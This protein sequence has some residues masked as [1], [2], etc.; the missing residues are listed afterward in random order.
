MTRK[1]KMPFHSCED[2]RIYYEIHGDGSPLLLISGLG[3]GTSSWYGQTP[4]FEQH[5]RTITFDNRG[6]GLSDTPPGPYRMSRFAEDALCLLDRLQIK[7]TFA[8]GLSMGGMIALEL[9]LTAPERIGALVLGC[10]H[11]GG[12]V[13]IA[14]SPEVLE[15]LLANEGLS[16]EQIID[17][18]LPLFFSE[19]CRRNRPQVVEAYRQEH[20]KRPPQPDDAF[21]AQLEAIRDFDCCDRLSRI[22]MPV[23][24]M[25]GT[26]DVL[27]PPRNSRILARYIPHAELVEIQG[28]GHAI[29][30]EC[31]DQ[32]NETAH[33]FFQRHLTRISSE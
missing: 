26:E 1:V 33:A 29:H 11:C 25:T 31:R 4:Y 21:R 15:R 23:L 17:K 9:A 12:T 18:N 16:Q 7:K 19:S 28:S 10:T 5:Y 8:L 30:A 20:L 24:I 13:R 3:G 6:A 22:E 32:L 27:V 2:T 14:P